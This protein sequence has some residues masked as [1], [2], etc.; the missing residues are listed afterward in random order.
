[1][2]IQRKIETILARGL[3]L[4]EYSLRRISEDKKY[5]VIDP[6]AQL[7]FATCNIYQRAG[8]EE[9]AESHINEVIYKRVISYL[10]EIFYKRRRC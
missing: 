3:E 6:V 2:L 10:R 8:N 9:Q 1:M 7:H 5:A 4:Q